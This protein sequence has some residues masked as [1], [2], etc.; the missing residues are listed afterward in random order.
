MKQ[1]VTTRQTVLVILEKDRQILFGKKLRGHG[2]GKWNGAG[3]TCQPDEWPEACARREVREELGITAMKLE[4]VAVLTF[5]QKPTIDDYSDLTTY[6]YLCHEWEGEPVE[7]AEL[8]ELTWFD[9]D[10]IPYGEMW[11]DDT[12][13]LPQVLAGEKVTGEFTFDSDYR[14][15]SHKVTV[16]GIDRPT[17]DISTRVEQ[18][19]SEDT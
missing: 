7:T 9:A 2:K 17:L 15:T 5:T 11:E 4:P 3:G 1:G 16:N 13:W 12:Y 19:L 6:V 10:A 18:I 8:G 14:M